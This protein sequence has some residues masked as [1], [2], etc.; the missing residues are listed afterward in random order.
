[1]IVAEVAVVAAEV[2]GCTVV[3]VECT[4][5]VDVE[6]GDVAVGMLCSA[7]V[8][9]ADG[10]IAAVEVVAA[11]IADRSVV[12]DLSY[13][14]MVVE[15]QGEVM[16]VVVLIMIHHDYVATVHMAGLAYNSGLLLQAIDQAWKEEV[17]DLEK[18]SLDWTAA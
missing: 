12:L 10:R 15:D 9:A 17:E 18:H 11:Y 2:G 13:S 14:G 16:S 8:A 5:D 3:L 6:L 7:I 4:M 1:L